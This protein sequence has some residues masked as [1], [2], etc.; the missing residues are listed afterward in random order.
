MKEFL[1]KSME[2]FLK[3]IL[4]DISGGIPG[5]T[6]EDFLENLRIISQAISRGTGPRRN[7]WRNS[8]MYPI[9]GTPGEIPHGAYG[10]F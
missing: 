5:R 2:K 8:R 6:I 4:S 7:L 1:I 9:S 3:K 10:G